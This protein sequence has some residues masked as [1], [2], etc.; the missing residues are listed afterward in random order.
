M[1]LSTSQREGKPDATDFGA[2]DSFNIGGKRGA[3]RQD[4][5]SIYSLGCIAR[6]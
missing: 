5:T 3:I 4:Q 1:I 2:P 6:G